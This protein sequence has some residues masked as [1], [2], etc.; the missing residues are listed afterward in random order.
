MA[1]GDPPNVAQE[2][3]LRLLAD[4]G[5]RADKR[6]VPIHPSVAHV[7]ENK[8]YI[9]FLGVTFGKRGGAYDVWEITP[10]GN[11]WLQKYPQPGSCARYGI[12]FETNG[13]RYVFYATVDKTIPEWYV[14]WVTGRYFDDDVTEVERYVTELTAHW[15]QAPVRWA[16]FPVHVN[17]E[18]DGG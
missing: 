15:F 4:A 11:D 8:G 5:G 9:R 12:E 10:F 14:E 3:A 17:D 16:W 1:I 2:R 7:L 6:Q 13:H 18:P